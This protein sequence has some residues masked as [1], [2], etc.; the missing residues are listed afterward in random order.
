MGMYHT[1]YVGPYIEYDVVMGEE[2]EPYQKCSQNEKH[3]V[4]PNDKFCSTC[5]S[6]VVTATKTIKVKQTFWNFIE[7]NEQFEEDTFFSVPDHNGTKTKLVL[8]PNS[9]DDAEDGFDF[10]DSS[11]VKQVPTHGIP[12]ILTKFFIKHSAL[13]KAF[14]YWTNVEVKYGVVSY[15]N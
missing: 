1:V 10:E 13:I 14:K 7:N 2:S 4:H 3:R 9:H 5:G 12:D 15:W 8:I 11:F 6:P